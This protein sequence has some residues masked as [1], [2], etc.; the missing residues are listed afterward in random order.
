M[1]FLI[2]AP[3]SACSSQDPE[4]GDDH[5]CDYSSAIWAEKLQEAL[6]DLKVHASLVFGDVSKHAIDLCSREA[7]STRWRERIKTKASHPN[8]VYVEVHSHSPEKFVGVV[9]KFKPM[10]KGKVPWWIGQIHQALKKHTNVILFDRP[11]DTVEEYSQMDIP[12]VYISF[13]N[14]IGPF[15]DQEIIEDLAAALVN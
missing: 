8:T 5:L 15:L 12:S 11:N 10:V 7:R 2:T 3:H 6:E 9:V 14:F 4:I 13:E 1:N